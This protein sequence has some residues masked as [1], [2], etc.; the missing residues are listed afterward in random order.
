M[1]RRVLVVTGTRAEFGL[2]RSTMAAVRSH[3]DLDLIVVAAGAHLLPPARTV[4]EVRA[5][6]DISAEVSMQVDGEIGRT[7]DSISLGRGVSGCAEAFARLQPDFVVVLGD[8]I[9]AFAAASAASVGGIPVAHLHG[10]DRA[11]GVADEAM[12]HAISQLADL[13]LAATETSGERL[14]RM[15]QDPS[16][17]HV[18]GSPA[19]DDLDAFPALE[20]DLYRELG[21]PRTMVLH[22]GCGSDSE[23]ETR[24]AAAV[25]DA[26]IE[27]GNTLVLDP[28]HDPGRDLIRTQIRT[29][30]NSGRLESV[31][32]LPRPVFVGM[33]RRI[34]ALVGNSSA[35]L[36]E[37]AVV[38][39]PAV[40]VGA[41]QGGRERPGS[42]IDVDPPS[43]NRVL[44][45]IRLAAT[46]GRRVEHPYGKPGVG[47]R[48]ASLLAEQTIPVPK[49]RLAY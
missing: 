15:G 35:G 24:E 41:R 27:H 34:D 33:L 20:E 11:E 7:A 25:L 12:R 47:G 9:E 49:K 39:C 32:H 40:N 42:V 1:T 48:I 37:A 8:R 44:E 10:G 43:K 31:T 16:M 2:L 6:F 3:P 36:I 17:I 45:A 26:A 18:V 22:H 23:R 30:A 5:E 46:S 21:S 28:N 38:G 4:E 14:R 13:H 19:V 29:R